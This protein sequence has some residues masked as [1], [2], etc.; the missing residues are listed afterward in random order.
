LPSVTDL[1]VDGCAAGAADGVTAA[2]AAYLTALYQANPEARKE[3]ETTDIAGR[4]AKML[5]SSNV[6]AR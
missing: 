4:M 3:A 5:A 2:D 6:V 1:F